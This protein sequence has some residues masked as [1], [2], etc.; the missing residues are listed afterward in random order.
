MGGV[1]G[2]VQLRRRLLV[3]GRRAVHRLLAAA[4]SLLAPAGGAWQLQ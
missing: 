4:G 1:Q 2:H 3:S